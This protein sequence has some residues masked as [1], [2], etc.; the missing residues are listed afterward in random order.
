VL[1]TGE[2][3]GGKSTVLRLLLRFYDVNSGRISIDGQ[4]LRDV[5]LASLRKNIGTVPQETVLFN[6]NNVQHLLRK[7]YSHR[8]R[9]P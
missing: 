3:G 6:E 2:S 4:D 5:K 1:T 9:S 7:T 8:Q